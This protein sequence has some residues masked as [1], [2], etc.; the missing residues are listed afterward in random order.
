MSEF[1]KK[2]LEVIKT[3]YKE[4]EGAELISCVPAMVQIKIV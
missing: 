4:I 3:K 1:I 2:E